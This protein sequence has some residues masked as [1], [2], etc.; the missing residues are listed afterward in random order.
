MVH[1]FSNMEVI[2]CTCRNKQMRPLLQHQKFYLRSLRHLRH[3]DNNN[4]NDNNNNEYN[5]NININDN[6]LIM[7]ISVR[8]SE[9]HANPVLS[10]DL[11]VTMWR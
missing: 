1:G 2:H 9:Q 3:H 8:D 7:V 10:Q 5:I 11:S 4:N 6:N